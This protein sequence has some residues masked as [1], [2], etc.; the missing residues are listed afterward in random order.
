MIN[1]KL[2]KKR[3][4][5]KQ[6]NNLVLKDYLAFKKNFYLIYHTISKHNC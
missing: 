4:S 2:Y 1:F 6:E 5:I 3:T